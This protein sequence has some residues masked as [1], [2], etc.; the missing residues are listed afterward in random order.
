ME[1]A[2]CGPA[3]VFVEHFVTVF[4]NEWCSFVL[5]MCTFV[6][7]CSFT[8]PSQK[9]CNSAE[10]AVMGEQQLETCMS[11]SLE[12]G[13]EVLD[14]LG[15]FLPFVGVRRLSLLAEEGVYP[16]GIFFGTTQM[17][18]LALVTVVSFLVSHDASDVKHT[19]ARVDKIDTLTVEPSDQSTLKTKTKT[20]TESVESSEMQKPKRMFQGVQNTK[21]DG[22]RQRSLANHA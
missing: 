2:R 21:P 15:V 13:K 4:G 1:P 19:K 14:F 12:V 18:G 20:K 11:F 16:P 9:G 22:V 7:C 5:V 10:R 17:V 6:H 3:S 8:L